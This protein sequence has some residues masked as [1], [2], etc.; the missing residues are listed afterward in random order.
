MKLVQAGGQTV[1]ETVREF[2]ISTDS[3]RRW[4]KQ[5]ERDAGNRQDGLSTPDRK[6]LAQPAVC[7]QITLGASS[8]RA[9]Y[10]RLAVGSVLP[11]G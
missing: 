7:T 9:C 4:L 10:P 1:S 11:L 5:T 3:V 8:D 6:E 2:E